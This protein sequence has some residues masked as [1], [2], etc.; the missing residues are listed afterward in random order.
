MN[1][2]KNEKFNT[3]LERLKSIS[4]SGIITLSKKKNKTLKN[5]GITRCN[6]NQWVNVGVIE[7]VLLGDFEY[8]TCTHIII[9][10]AID[11]LVTTE[12]TDS[13]VSRFNKWLDFPSN[14]YFAAS[15]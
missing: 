1:F 13:V 7:M 3:K 4:S 15:Q 12:V 8:L 5:I 2:K 10:L 11:V 14:F 9:N 6:D